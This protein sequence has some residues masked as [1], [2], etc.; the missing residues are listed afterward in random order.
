MRFRNIKT[1]G[2][3]CL[4]FVC[5]SFLSGCRVGTSDLFVHP[6]EQGYE[7]E[8]TY[9]C[10]GGHINTVASRSVYYAEGA[11]LWEPQGTKGMLVMPRNG[12]KTLLGWYT[13]YT[14]ENINGVEVAV[15][16][17][18]DQWDFATDRLNTETAPDKKLTLYARWA[19]NPNICFVDA[20]E[21][22]A[23]AYL[24]WNMNVGS[25]L[26]R[27]TSSEPRK[28][29]HTLLDYYLDEACTEKYIFDIPITEELIE[30]DAAGNAVVY[31]YCKFIEGEFTRIRTSGQ[32]MAIAEEPAGVYVL[33]CDIDLGGAPVT[34]LGE[35]TG[36]LYGNGYTLSGLTVNAK[37]RV[38]GVAAMRTPD[39]GFGLFASL[40][41]AT[42]TGLR[43]RDVQIIVDAASN[44]GVCLGA[45]AGI[46]TDA[47]IQ[48][49]EI[50][51]LQ[52][53]AQE[54]VKVNVTAAPFAVTNEDAPTLLEGCVAT[55]V[56]MDG[57]NG[58]SGTV[59]IIEQAGE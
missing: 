7:Y 30:T 2:L 33:A 24:T 46:A 43:L 22:D 15:F 8:V 27:P 51:G 54:G 40:N 11:L 31:V 59:T 53:V 37:H 14:T 57:L 28:A 58:A 9:D 13:A 18:A 25:I 3:G 48:N 17:E 5:A 32:F 55:G 56:E 39:A 16:D 19:E 47:T 21:P 4:L 35:F 26:Q 23:G 45:L 10:M 20:D 50:D 36:V 41:G 44:V 42:V 49:C 38:G 34:P 29:G 6:S 1:I 52:L 12:A